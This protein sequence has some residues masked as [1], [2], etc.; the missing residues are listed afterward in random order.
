MKVIGK[1]INPSYQGI[2][3]KS[4]SEEKKSETSVGLSSEPMPLEPA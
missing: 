4:G 3:V 1:V 2:E